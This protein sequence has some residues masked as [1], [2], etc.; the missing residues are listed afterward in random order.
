MLY[1]GPWQEMK[2][3]QLAAS[4]HETGGGARRLDPP[5]PEAVYRIF[6]PKGST[7]A[8]VETEP[9]FELDD[10][11]PIDA[12]KNRAANNE[13]IP[14]DLA[15]GCAVGF[16][17]SLASM[18]T[19]SLSS[20]YSVPLS[21]RSEGS[22]VGSRIR[23][24]S[25]RTLHRLNADPSGKIRNRNSH[26]RQMRCSTNRGGDP[27]SLYSNATNSCHA[28]LSFKSGHEN[29]FSKFWK[30]TGTTHDDRSS[31]TMS[32]KRTGIAKMFCDVTKDSLSE[33]CAQLS[34]SIKS[35]IPSKTKH[36]SSDTVRPL[37][38]T[39]KVESIA[40]LNDNLSKCLDL[41]VDDES[42]SMEDLLVWAGNLDVE[43]LN[44]SR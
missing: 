28:M 22:E 24:R 42:M 1:I 40:S 2:L 17:R 20:S 11:P 38:K 6:H 41:P 21:T 35:Q 34:P 30:W 25:K 19:S 10:V 18:E 12:D 27:N 37:L 16:S 44:F 26:T 13:R 9:Y 32:G 5:P 23:Q 43:S 4:N 8:V 36:F 7:T 3:A 15:N 33:I 14:R 31:R 39:E 29:E